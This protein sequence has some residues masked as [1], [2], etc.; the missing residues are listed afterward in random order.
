MLQFAIFSLSQDSVIAIPAD[1]W[2]LELIQPRLKCVMQNQQCVESDFQFPTGSKRVE[3]EAGRNQGLVASD[4]PP[5]IMD[6]TVKTVK[7][8]ANQVSMGLM[9]VKMTANQV[10]MG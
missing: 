3:V 10:S 1:Q 2:N 9:C 4:L 5:N 7:M 8:S 6:I